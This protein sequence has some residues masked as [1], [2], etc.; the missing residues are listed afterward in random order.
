M[1]VEPHPSPS[2]WKFYRKNCPFNNK[3]NT[4]VVENTYYSPAMQRCQVLAD[5]Q[6]QPRPSASL[7]LI[8]IELCELVEHLCLVL[9]RDT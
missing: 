7:Q 3:I 9:F 1:K 8:A 6:P 5:P 2:E 4:F